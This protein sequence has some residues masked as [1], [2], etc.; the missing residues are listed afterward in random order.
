ML[1]MLRSSFSRPQAKTE[2]AKGK[3]KPESMCAQMKVTLRG[4][5]VQK[6]SLNIGG[7]IALQ[8]SGT[9]ETRKL[10]T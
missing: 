10:C 4:D 3:I 9:L 5:M 2:P 8:C 6:T 7:G 1:K